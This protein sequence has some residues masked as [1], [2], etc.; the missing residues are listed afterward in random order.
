MSGAENI[1]FVE[2]VRPGDSQT[3]LFCAAFQDFFD[4]PQ[5]FDTFSRHTIHTVRTNRIIL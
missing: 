4:F 3:L 2:L 5:H 1:Y